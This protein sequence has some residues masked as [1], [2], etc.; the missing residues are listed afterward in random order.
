MRRYG[1][2]RA[3]GW[4]VGTIDFHVEEIPVHPVGVPS[5]LYHHLA[6]AVL[7]KDAFVNRKNK[8]GGMFNGETEAAY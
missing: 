5:L 2:P 8:Q 4:L 7:C 1:R 6:L 3:R